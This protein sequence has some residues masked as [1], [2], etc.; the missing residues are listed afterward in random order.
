[1]AVAYG[2]LAGQVLR[3]YLPRMGGLLADPDP[4]VRQVAAHLLARSCGDPAALAPVLAA[5]AAHEAEPR[6]RAAL[7]TVLAGL[8]R[9]L[10]SAADGG[11]ALA[12]VG[13]A[14]RG[15]ATRTNK[16]S[17]HCGRWPRSP[18]TLRST[19]GTEGGAYRLHQFLPQRDR[20]QGRRL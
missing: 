7:P 18:R 8:V 5:R 11:V 10:R 3:A 6:V 1:L 2:L 14:L 9:R 16:P 17:P 15:L 19:S 13:G 4:E 20:H 12:P